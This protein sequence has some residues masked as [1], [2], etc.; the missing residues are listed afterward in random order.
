M[1]NQV[2]QAISN[3]QSNLDSF[4][5]TKENHTENNQ[6]IEEVIKF[7]EEKLKQ[8]IK[9]EK[10]RKTTEVQELVLGFEEKRRNWQKFQKRN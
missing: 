3:R 6:A 7:E 4:R 10:K 8:K 9:L 2:R 5:N 1:D